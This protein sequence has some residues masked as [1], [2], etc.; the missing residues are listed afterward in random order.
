MAVENGLGL[1]GFLGGSSTAVVDAPVINQDVVKSEVTPKVDT[2]PDKQADATKTEA[3]PRAAREAKVEPVIDAK[4]DKAAEPVKKEG[5]ESSPANNWEKQYK[6]TQKWSMQLSNENSAL[7]RQLDVIN[8]K[9]DGTYDP[10]LDAPKV[11][12]QEEA[13]HKALTL[14]KVQTSVA[15]AAE[16]YKDK[17]GAAYIEKM[18]YAPD[19]PFRKFDNNP[20]IQSLVLNSDAPVLAAMKIL[21]HGEFTTKWGN[22]PEKIEAAIRKKVEEELTEQLTKDVEAKIM[23]RFNLK[24]KQVQGLGAVRSADADSGNH[25]DGSRPL[26]SIL[27]LG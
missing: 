6:D 18:I 21:E 16:I 2:S 1:E 20:M 4:P 15:M 10:V 5:I 26:A 9:L 8:K 23:Q 14:G 13:T 17:G 11:D 7:K 24:G 19:A 12:T 27:P 22:S 25:A 3:K